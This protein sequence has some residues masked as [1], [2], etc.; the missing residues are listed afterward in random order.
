MR[1]N[2][3]N[4]VLCSACAACLGLG[5]LTAPVSAAGLGAKGSTGGLVIPVAST[6]PDRGMALGYG[7]YR[8]ARYDYVPNPWYLLFGL[9]L[10]PY[11]EVFGRYADYNTAPHGAFLH[12]EAYRGNRDL[13]ANLKVKVPFLP[14]RGPQVALGIN[15][16]AG[17]NPLFEATYA[18]ATQEWRMFSVSVGYV[19][20]MSE[21]DKDVMFDGAFGGVEWR[22]GATGLALLAEYD[23]QTSHAGGRWRSPGLKSLGDLSAEATLHHIFDRPLPHRDASGTTRFALGLHW[24]LGRFDEYRKLYEPAA[25]TRHRASSDADASDGAMNAS[26][27]ASSASSASRATIR[28]QDLA[29]LRQRLE[30]AGLE[31]VRVGLRPAATAARGVSSG[32]DAFDSNDSSGLELV[33]EYENHRYALNEVDALGLVF[34]LGVELAPGARRVRAITLKDGLRVYETGVDAASYREFLQLGHE[35]RAGRDAVMAPVRAGLTWRSGHENDDGVQWERETPTKA[36]RLRVE[37]RPDM[38][39]TLGTE[40]GAFDY[41]LAARP[42]LVAPLWS[43]ARLTADYVI[44]VDHS[45]NME[46]D[47]V[48]GHMRHSQGLEHVSL[49]QSFWL[50]R[51]VLFNMAAGRFYFDSWGLQAEGR[52]FVPG[53]SGVIR[54]KGAA[55]RPA[56]DGLE[57]GDLAGLAVYRHFWGAGHWVDAGWQAYGDGT[58][59]PSF[60]WTR[61][62]SDVGVTLFGRQGGPTRVAGLM[63][64]VPLTPRRGMKPYVATVSGPGQYTESIRTILAAEGE[65][66]PVEPSWV[67][68][69][70]LETELDRDMLNGGRMNRAYVADQLYRMREAYHKYGGGL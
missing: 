39:Y 54:L 18:V 24:P 68:N 50:G 30:A 3:L 38:N 1:I 62:S 57:A 13:S 11:V 23:G 40:L 42:R 19:R 33:V 43:G 8:E 36:T 64:T 52:V 61:W 12:D 46:D 27:A 65:A 5:G 56:L 26:A 16:V 59:G 4:R 14:E 21:D 41:S 66:N 34:G 67:R 28:V 32:S 15:D 25:T 29:P 2:K 20:G 31:R 47:R 44:P 17:G 6:L 22:L 37:A 9:G 55:Y 60:E 69:L 49:G 7:N 70:T 63:V 10:S 45:L 48:F 35:G 51:R 58:G 53:T